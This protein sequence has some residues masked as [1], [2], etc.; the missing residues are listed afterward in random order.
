MTVESELALMRAT[1]LVY[2]DQLMSPTPVKQ[3]RIVYILSPLSEAL[4][5]DVRLEMVK[6]GADAA[7]IQG[8]LADFRVMMV[9][10]EG[11]KIYR[12]RAIQIPRGAIVHVCIDFDNAIEQ[13]LEKM[14]PKE[15]CQECGG[16]DTGY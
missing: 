10:L 2:R 6:V 12:V 7:I 9:K 14:W 13:D 1:Q 5:I 16:H 3:C 15:R 8:G 11:N 4:E